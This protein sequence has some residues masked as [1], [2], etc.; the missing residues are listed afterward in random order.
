[1][2]R[3]KRTFWYFVDVEGGERKQGKAEPIS[4]IVQLIELGH[5]VLIIVFFF[6]FVIVVDI[7]RSW[8][9]IVMV[10]VFGI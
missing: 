8:S 3:C 4:L 9:R 7:I 5:H 2:T 1:M 6:F 10:V